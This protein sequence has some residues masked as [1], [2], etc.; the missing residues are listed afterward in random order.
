MGFVGHQVHDVNRSARNERFVC[1]AEDV[2]YRFRRFLMENAE[3]IHGIVA[4]GELAGVKITRKCY[5]PTVH[6]LLCDEFFSDSND[7][8]KIHHRT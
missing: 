4:S 8:G 5:H 6:F 1:P 7:S 3:N 2:L